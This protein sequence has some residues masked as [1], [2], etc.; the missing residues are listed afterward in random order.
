MTLSAVTDA[1]HRALALWAAQCAEHVLVRF[2]SVRPADERPRAAIAAARAWAAG[3]ISV[4]EARAAAFASHGAGRDAGDVAARAA[5]RSAGHAAATAHLA[6][7]ARHAATYA[8]SAAGAPRMR[9]DSALERS[10]ATGLFLII[11]EATERAWQAERLPARLH[12]FALPA[13]S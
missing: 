3:E 1:D 10:R 5:A 13:V 2:E 9:V 11:D 6:G 7:H 8:V 4:A 12:P